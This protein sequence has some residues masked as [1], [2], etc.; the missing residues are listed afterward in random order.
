MHNDYLGAGRQVNGSIIIDL[1][2]SGLLEGAGTDD[3][4]L[5]GLWLEFRAWCRAN[6]VGCPPG[7][8][9]KVGL[10]RESKKK[11]PEM[12]SVFKA[13]QMKLVTAFLASKTRAVCED[14][15]RQAGV[16]PATMLR[17][18][19]RA[20]CIWGLA[21]A[22]Y[23]MDCGRLLLPREHAVECKRSIYTYLQCVQ[24][25][26]HDSQV[27]GTYMYYIKPKCHYIEHQ[28]MELSETDPWSL[29]PRCV[30]CMC[31][32]TFMGKLLKIGKKTHS[33][34]ASLRVLQR[35]L[36]FIAIRWE[37]RRRLKRWCI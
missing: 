10:N 15:Q 22:E 31:D 35:Y 25:L 13:C 32:E 26:S 21:N 36:L 30:S 23:I 28:A 34:T 18:K 1:L 3:T 17:A 33:I 27:R 14:L 9:T 12:P 19:V 6:R 37:K 8:F 7:R 11:Y 4:I 24:W 5:K 20:S 29:N 16:P 2:E